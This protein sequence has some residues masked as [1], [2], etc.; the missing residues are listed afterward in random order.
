[1]IEVDQTQEFPELALCGRSW[2]IADGLDFLWQGVDSMPVDQVSEE[3]K[4]LHPKLAL[5]WI[6]DDSILLQSLQDQ[7]EVAE[8]K[9]VVDVCVAEVKPPKHLVN[10]PLES[11]CCIS[12]SKG[13]SG[14]L[15]VQMEWKW[16]SLECPPHLQAFGG[17]LSLR[18]WFCHVVRP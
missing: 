10:E 16:Q 14:K 15:R 6:D 13:H 3:F 11:L 12:Q 17:R 9:E 2:E 4:A 5:S 8:N 7:P 18:R 1:M